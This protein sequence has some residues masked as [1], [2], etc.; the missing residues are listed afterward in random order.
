MF[1]GRGVTTAENFADR[2]KSEWQAYCTL[3]GWSAVVETVFGLHDQ[4]TVFQKTVN[5]RVM[6]SVNELVWQTQYML[7]SGADSLYEISNELN[8]TPMGCLGM[9]VP[10]DRIR[11]VT[12]R[13][14]KRQRSSRD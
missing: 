1:P 6:G 3:R 10:E 9:D 2:L 8:Q 4:T 5:R 14:L 7:S 11:L 13:P 12:L